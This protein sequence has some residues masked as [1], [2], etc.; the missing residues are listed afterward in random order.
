MGRGIKGSHVEDHIFSIHSIRAR[1]ERARK[2]LNKDLDY[3]FWYK[4]LKERFGDGEYY[5]YTREERDQMF[6]PQVAAEVAIILDEA[7]EGIVG[8]GKKEEKAAGV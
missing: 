2:V 3:S 8:S 7:C 6:L 1:V 4:F 5:R